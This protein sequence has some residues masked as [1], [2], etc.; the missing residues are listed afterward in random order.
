MYNNN[1]I[2][3][4]IIKRKVSNIKLIGQKVNNPIKKGTYNIYSIELNG[5]KKPIDSDTYIELL[6]T[7]TKDFTILATEMF[8]V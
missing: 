1:I 2:F 8:L 3:Q 6:H 4:P 7:S 5:I